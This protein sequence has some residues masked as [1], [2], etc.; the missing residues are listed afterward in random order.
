MGSLYD[1]RSDVEIPE[2]LLK[3]IC[4]RKGHKESQVR[5]IKFNKPL[6]A[7]S[8]LIIVK[9]WLFLTINYYLI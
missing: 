9:A 7:F 2:D 3:R 1:G 5:E 4:S 8:G 6:K